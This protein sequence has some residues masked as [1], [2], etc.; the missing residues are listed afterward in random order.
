MADTTGTGTTDMETMGMGTTGTDGVHDLATSRLRDSSQRYTDGRREL[1]DALAELGQPSTVHE[2]IDQMDSASQSTAY[3][4]LAVLER[5]GVVVRI[6]TGDDFARFELAQDL[7]GH[8]HHL[9]CP[10]CGGVTDFELPDEFERA[11]ETALRDA[12]SEHGFTPADHRLDVIGTC[13]DCT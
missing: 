2:V 4:N 6:V 12:S 10:T 7:T 11:M 13:A 5:A 9:V 1:V 3:R 8:H